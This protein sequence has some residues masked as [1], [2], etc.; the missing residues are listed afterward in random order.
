MTARV[1][2]LC[3]PLGGVP[4]GDYIGFYGRCHCGWQ[5]TTP[6]IT[7]AAAISTVVIEHGTTPAPLG[8]DVCG[9]LH[10]DTPAY[11][12]YRPVIAVDVASDAHR[13]VWV[14][15]DTAACFRRLEETNRMI[16]NFDT[17]LH[18]LLENADGQ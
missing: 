3:Y 17:E 9:E 7:I 2:P 5:S 16:G 11:A 13:E 4:A 1:Q 10:D 8:C 18:A 12:V 14:C 15:R 6:T